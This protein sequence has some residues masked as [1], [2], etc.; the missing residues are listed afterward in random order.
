M[1][2]ALPEGFRE[3]ALQH[4]LSISVITLAHRIN[5]LGPFLAHHSLGAITEKHGKRVP[6]TENLQQSEYCT[7]LLASPNLTPLQ[8]AIC[9]SY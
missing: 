3:L 9:I 4:R 8:R 2:L 5:P 7:R 6:N 1:I